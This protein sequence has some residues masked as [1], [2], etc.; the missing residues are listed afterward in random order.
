MAKIL[1]YIIVN[2]IIIVKPVPLYAEIN[3]QDEIEELKKPIEE[4]F[5]LKELNTNIRNRNKLYD[6]NI[7]EYKVLFT[8]QN[9]TN[10]KLCP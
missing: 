5:G 2:D 1:N 7:S 9:N 10:E 8:I 6:T 3:T 4:W